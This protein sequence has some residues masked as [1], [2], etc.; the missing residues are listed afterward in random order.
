MRPSR[1]RLRGFREFREP[2]SGL[3]HL[4][5]G[6][7]AAVG[8]VAL[9]A[10]AVMAGSAERG[11]AFGVYGASLVGLYA[12]SALYHLLPVSERATARLRKL[13]HAMIFV[14]IAGTYTPVCL[15]ALSGPWRWGLL[16]TVWTLAIC[17]VLMKLRRI[18]SRS[19]PTVA[20]YLGLGWLSVA[21]LPKLLE[22][23]P[24]GALVWLAAGGLVY[25]AGAVIYATKRPDL[26]PGSFGHHGLWHLFVIAGSACHFWALARYVAPLG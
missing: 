9:L 20:L 8:L 5:G 11:V 14:L 1:F 13:D 17:G 24:V 15:L 6:V 2:F 26:L 21:A 16:G 25:S 19:W 7:L 3:S 12:A 22:A 23:L 4:V 18:G 10:A